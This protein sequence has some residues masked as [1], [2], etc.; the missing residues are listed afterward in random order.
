MRLRTYT[1]THAPTSAHQQAHTN[2]RTPTSAR[3]KPYLWLSC[4]DLVRFLHD[5]DKLEG[6][7]IASLDGLTASWRP[8]N[9]NHLHMLAHGFASAW[10]R[11]IIPQHRMPTASHQHQHQRKRRTRRRSHL[12]KDFPDWEM[13][14]TKGRRH[15]TQNTRFRFVF[16]CCSSLLLTHTH[17]H[18]LSLFSL[19]LPPSSIPCSLLS[20]FLVAA[21]RQKLWSL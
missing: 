11:H 2:K 5:T 12:R 14:T 21:T 3:W 19:S 17:T 10:K 16:L 1:N 6:E 20:V 15:N 13:P 18:S 9:H 7:V 4:K 8:F